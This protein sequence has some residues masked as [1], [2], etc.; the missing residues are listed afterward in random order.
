MHFIHSD[1]GISAL[2]AWAREFQLSD[3]GRRH[4]WVSVQCLDKCHFTRR[5]ARF[6]T[7]ASP[8][9]WPQAGAR[10]VMSR[11]E[12]LYFDTRQLLLATI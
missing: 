5:V 2:T 4:K 1:A 3:V 11:V 9:A 12:L 6:T 10:M 8:L 7:A